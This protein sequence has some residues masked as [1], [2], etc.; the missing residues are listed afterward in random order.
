MGH[1]GTLYGRRPRCRCI[2]AWPSTRRTALP[3]WPLIGLCLDPRL[4]SGPPIP[5]MTSDPVTTRSLTAAPPTI[6]HAEQ[7]RNL[8]QR[9]EPFAALGPAGLALRRSSHFGHRRSCWTRVA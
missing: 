4:Y 7:L 9:H 3:G 5:N 2:I 8:E 6:E 1:R